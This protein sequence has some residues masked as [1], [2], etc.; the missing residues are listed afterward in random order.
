[1]FEPKNLQIPIP[2]QFNKLRDLEPFSQD[3]F[4]RIIEFQEHLHPAWNPERPFAERIRRLP[5]H[6]LIFSNPD[7][8]P[9][10]HSHTV[11]AF[12]P[13]RAEMRQI[14]Q[15]ARQVA[16]DPV[17]CDVHGRNG[18]IG[19]LLG[20]EGAKVIGLTDPAD[21]PNQIPSF[22]DP[23]CYTPLA[24]DIDTLVRPFDVAFSAWMPSGINRT[25][26]IVRY[27]PKLI[28]FVH[29]DHVD[30]STGRPQ[31]GTEDAYRK[32]PSN[33]QLIAEW[34]IERPEDL[35]HEVWPDLTRSIAESRHVKIFADEPYQA[36]HVT[37]E[38][39][40]VD[41]YDWEK[42]LDMA[43]TAYEAKQA[44]RAKGMPV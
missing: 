2:E 16:E 10:T 37:R 41:P 30:E 32:L 6:A 27:R 31:T 26:A 29:T 35:L 39:E 20:R 5:L 1:M 8:N 21:K 19:S 13:M 17:I 40:A 18:F 25:P 14:V 7:R 43:L 44:L 34:S 15:C 23:E 24:A 11:A 4:N 3:M 9:A 22:Y 42:D 12:Y 36:I 28:V 33:Y 38:M